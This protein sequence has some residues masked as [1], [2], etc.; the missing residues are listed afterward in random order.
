[1]KREHDAQVLGIEGLLTTYVQAGQAAFVDAA[2]G[3]GVLTRPS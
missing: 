3:S 1:M 2:R